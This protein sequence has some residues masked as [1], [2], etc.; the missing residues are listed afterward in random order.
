MVAENVTLN[1]RESPTLKAAILDKKEGGSLV[2][3]R[4]VDTDQGEWIKLAAE[5]GYVKMKKGDRLVVQRKVGMEGGIVKIS[6]TPNTNKYCPS[7]VGLLTTIKT[8][9]RGNMPYKVD[10]CDAWLYASDVTVLM[11]GSLGYLPLQLNGDPVLR[12]VGR[13]EWMV[14]ANVNNFS[15]AY[16]RSKDLNDKIGSYVDNKSKLLAVCLD[17]EWLAVEYDVKAAEE[18]LRKAEEQKR[19]A[20]EQKRKTAEEAK[21]TAKEQEERRMLPARPLQSPQPPRISGIAVVVPPGRL[22]YTLDEPTGTLLDVDPRGVLGRAGC[23]PGVVIKAVNGVRYS[24][25][26]LNRCRTGRSQYEIVFFSQRQCRCPRG[27]V[28][29]IYE[30]RPGWFRS[31][32]KCDRCRVAAPKHVPMFGCGQCN[33]DRCLSCHR[34][35]LIRS[36]L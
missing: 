16:R 19:K 3:G 13:G 31:G 29:E 36:G 1:V 8:D 12:E 5:P 14:L 18:K 30:S 6:S 7:L 2:L 9:D 24:I 26:H 35:N 17:E 27:H 32:N 20:E 34:E 33:W 23:I 10:A 25:D 11:P 21:R 4:L 15:L 22:N 28:A